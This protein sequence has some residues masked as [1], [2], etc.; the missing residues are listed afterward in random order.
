[1][2]GEYPVKEFLGSLNSADHSGLLR[3][4]KN[5]GMSRLGARGDPRDAVQRIAPAENL[6]VA[7]FK[8]Q[9]AGAL[10]LPC[11]PLRRGAVPWDCPWCQ[12]R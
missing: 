12:A 10:T 11:N 1:M 4:G 6:Q 2:L 5:G 7:W 8:I 9:G 3:A